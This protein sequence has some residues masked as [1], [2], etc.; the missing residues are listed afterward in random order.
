MDKEYIIIEDSAVFAIH[1]GTKEDKSGNI[2]YKDKKG[3]FHTI[4]F[5]SCSLNYK[6][7]HKNSSALCVGERDVADGSFIFYTSGIKTK[8]SFKKR[9]ILSTVF[10]PRILKGA[11]NKRFHTLNALI[12]RAGFTTYDLS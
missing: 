1:I 10:A 11:K 6:E 8:L 2:I 4:D 7:Q 9:Y 5:A 3:D 12:N